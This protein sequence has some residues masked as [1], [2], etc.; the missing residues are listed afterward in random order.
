VEAALA[1]LRAMAPFL[2]VLG[3]YPQAVG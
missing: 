2:R 3:S 1:E